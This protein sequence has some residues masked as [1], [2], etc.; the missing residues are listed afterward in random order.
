MVVVEPEPDVIEP[1]PH[2]I[3]EL[4]EAQLRAAMDTLGVSELT[5][6]LVEMVLACATAKERMWDTRAKGVQDPVA[7]SSAQQPDDVDRSKARLGVVESFTQMSNQLH[8]VL[9]S[10]CRLPTAAMC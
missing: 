5:D 10:T 3:K 7:A 1:D 2:V 9:L 6:S 4:A 8:G